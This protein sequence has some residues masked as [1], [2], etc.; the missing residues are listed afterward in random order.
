[1]KH[2]QERF[3]ILRPLSI[4]DF[5]LLWTGMSVSMVG[6]GVTY[7]ALA[8][9][10]YEL[11]NVPTA[12]SIVGVAW[13]LPMLVFL[14]IG[15]VVS[16]RFE[17]RRVMILSDVVRGL[18]VATMGVLAITGRIELW[19]IFVLIAIYGSGESFFWPSFGAIVPDLVPRGLLVEA[20]SLE[21]ALRR[22]LAELAAR[23]R[24]TN[25][26][27]GGSPARR[28]VASRSL[29]SSAPASGSARCS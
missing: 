3:K 20:N 4:R 14:L 28:W 29:P 13:T 9:Q 12:M 2:L 1:V 18:S 17:R 11:W 8:W 22:L 6:D 5:A 15:G 27:S 10:V 23:S 16:D 21:E 19:H 7:V 26:R 25:G 24:W